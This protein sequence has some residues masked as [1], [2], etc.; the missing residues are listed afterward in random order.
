[1]INFLYIE[2]TRIT[3]KKQLGGLLCN[4]LVNWGRIEN[5][6]LLH[7]KKKKKTKPNI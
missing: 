1:M 3:K 6:I 7:M 5:A 2:K 4:I